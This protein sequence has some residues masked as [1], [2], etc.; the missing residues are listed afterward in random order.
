MTAALIGLISLQFY[1]LNV[2]LSVNEEKFKHDVQEALNEVVHKL[3]MQ[4]AVKVTQRAIGEGVTIVY[5]SAT[6]NVDSAG[7]VRWLEEKLVRSTQLIGTERLYADGV[8]YSVEEEMLIQRSGIARKRDVSELPL[9]KIKFMEEEKQPPFSLGTPKPTVGDLPI[10]PRVNDSTSLFDKP[11][12][13]FN[14]STLKGGISYETDNS[15]SL[16]IMKYSDMVASIINELVNVSKGKNILDLINKQVLDSLIQM[17]LYDRGIQLPY[18]FGIR[19]MNK[20]T[21][22]FL[23][24]NAPDLQGDIVEEGYNVRL[25]PTNPYG[26]RNMLYLHFPDHQKFVFGKMW[27]VLIS[28]SIFLILV[29]FSFSYAIRTI[30]RQK[31][32]SE[33]TN[34]FIGNMTHELKTPIATVSLATEALLDPDIQAMPKQLDRYLNVIKDENA[35][36]GKQ[37]EKVLNIAR[38]DKGDFKLNISS[39]DVHAV[40]EKAYK[41]S[42]L[43]IEN[44]GGVLKL[45]LNATNSQIEADR[46]HFTN[47]IHNLLDNANKYSP[48]APHLSITTTSDAKG[49]RILIADRGRGI[50][51]DMV[52]KIFD[53]FYRVPTGN[54]HDVKGFGLGLS[55]VK[56]MIDAHHGRIS[57]KSE[58]DKGSIFTIFLP[59]KH[60]QS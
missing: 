28:S 39:L 30:F 41:N 45:F 35:R 29:I 21:A 33:I 32:L 44:R 48:E 31:K 50:P 16:Q 53:K 36:L 10:I 3:E 49:L 8:A 14:S 18:Y 54:V 13:N 34:D 7:N 4:D 58:L 40:I 19:D 43:Q 60:E 37:V 52:N 11:N 27:M 26:T 2:S 47:I 22:D 6:V 51:K 57:V 15:E 24:T 38:F 9:E 12:L 20:P 25:F 23:Y 1:W 17:E 56:T 5:D 55:Y 59:Y 42:I 46:L